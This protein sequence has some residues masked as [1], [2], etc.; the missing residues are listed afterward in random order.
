MI[1]INIKFCSSQIAFIHYTQHVEK[2]TVK[3]EKKVKKIMKYIEKRISK[4]QEVQSKPL[5]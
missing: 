2:S 1:N 4:M 5:Y 3:H